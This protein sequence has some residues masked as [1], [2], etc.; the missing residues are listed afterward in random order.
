M[1]HFILILERLFMEI[2]VLGETIDVKIYPLCDRTCISRDGRVFSYKRGNEW[3]ELTNN[4]DKDG[5]V[6]CSVSGCKKFVHRLVAITYIE[7]KLA[8]PQINHKNGNKKDN[9]VE[10]LEW[11]TS[12]ENIRHAIDIGLIVVKRGYDNPM[13]IP[14]YS[15]NYLGER[16]GGYG[17]LREACRELGCSTSSLRKACDGFN[18]YGSR[19]VCHG[20]LWSRDDVDKI[21]V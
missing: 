9:R 3:R 14:I 15:Y 13:S 12:L 21:Y 7:N 6:V 17:S 1:F 11:V 8:K 10:N 18:S 2:E 19:K 20:L 4:V 16:V 5:Y